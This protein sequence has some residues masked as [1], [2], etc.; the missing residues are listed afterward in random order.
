MKTKR[1]T[2]YML[3][4]YGKY[5]DPRKEK[6]FFRKQGMTDPLYMAH[7]EGECRA[8]EP[9]NLPPRLRAN[10]YPPGRRHKAYEDGFNM[11]DPLGDYHGRNE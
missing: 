10:P 8:Y 7:L 4:M 11:A 9:H 1:P 5:V 2:A 6:R 3:S